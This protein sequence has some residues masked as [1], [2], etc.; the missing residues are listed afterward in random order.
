MNKNWVYIRDTCDTVRVINVEHIVE[1]R[2][3]TLPNIREGY[4]YK[5]EPCSQVFL[6]NGTYFMTPAK[7]EELA[8]TIGF[9]TGWFKEHDDKDTKI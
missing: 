9:P 2:S 3:S 5:G 4:R 6:S 1:I 7:Q 8:V